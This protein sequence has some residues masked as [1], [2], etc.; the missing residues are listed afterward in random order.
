MFTSCNRLLKP[1]TYL[2]FFFFYMKRLGIVKHSGAYVA[3]F[4]PFQNLSR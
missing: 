3:L 2:F 4:W 1:I